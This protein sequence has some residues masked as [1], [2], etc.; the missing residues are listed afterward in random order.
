[1]KVPFLAA[2]LLLSTCFPAIAGA[3]FYIDR[4]ADGIYAAI[5]RP[6]GK[7]TSNAFFVEGDDYVVIGGAHLTKE[8]ITQL[9]SAVK[10]ITDKPVRYYILSHHHRGFSHIDFDVPAGREVIMSWQ[11]WQ[12]VSQEFREVPYPVLFY[13]DGIT[14]KLGGRT[15]ILTNVEKGHTEGD[16]LVYLPEAKVLFTSDLV[17]S[18]RI[19][20]LGDG[21]MQEWVLALELME[22]LNAEKIIPGNGPVSGPRAIADFKSFL[23]DFLTEVL[24][25]I[26]RGESLETAE[27]S[28]S[29]P[30][31]QN[32]PGYEMFFKTNFAR[33][34]SDLKSGMNN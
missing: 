22:R 26:E 23:R 31:H 13:S 10:A 28:F 4:V 11:T 14:L 2:F 1:M 8:A 6:S 7:I 29:L 19:G 15:M 18:D 16:T 24:G 21:H 5:T 20:Y 33:A 27:R 34:Y 30:R 25:H 32:T 9:E 12:G 17:Y 3:G